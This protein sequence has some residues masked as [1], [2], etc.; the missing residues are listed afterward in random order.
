MHTL[1]CSLPCPELRTFVRA[2]AQR[3]MYDLQAPVVEAMPPQLESVIEFPLGIDTEIIH[4]D[5]RRERYPRASVIGLQTHTSYAV[6]KNKSES[7]GVFF[8]PAGISQLL[9]VSMRDISNHNFEATS[10][11]GGWIHRLWNRLGEAPSFAHRVR[12][13][14]AALLSRARKLFKYDPILDLANAM[15]A[16]RGVVSIAGTASRQGIGLRQFE[17]IFVDKVGIAPKLYARIARF[18]TALDAKVA[19]P[20]RAWIE[21]AHDLKYH[22]QMHMVHDFQSLAGDSPGAIAS[23]IGDI[24]VPPL[25][26][27]GE[28][29][30]ISQV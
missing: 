2:Y 12:L 16:A 19:S 27:R 23:K 10:M 13:V 8:H 25:I 9:G 17:R 5:G 21:I 6:L 24:R 15:L 20:S 18:Q 4:W 7:F 29:H 26:L 14:E 30:D 1:E 3:Q 22:D 11:L 28:Q